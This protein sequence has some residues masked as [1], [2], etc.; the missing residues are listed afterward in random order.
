ME[1]DFGVDGDVKN[2]FG[3][4]DGISNP[5]V[6][7]SGISLENNT[8]RPIAA[9]EFVLGYKG[10]AGVVPPMPQPEV[11]GKTVRLWYCENTAVMSL[12]FT[13]IALNKATMT[14]LKPINWGQNVWSLAFGCPIILSPDHD[15]EA[16]GKDNVANNKFDYTDDPYGKG[17]PFGAHARRMNPAIPKILF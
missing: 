7:G 13:A 16:L 11:L 14:Q 15:D 6:D 4:R 9:G 3:Y 17:C 12:T 1:H 2:V 8:E 10:E 5:E